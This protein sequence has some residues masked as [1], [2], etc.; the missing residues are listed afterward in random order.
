QLGGFDLAHEFGWVGLLLV[1]VGIWSC[2]LADRAFWV[3]IMTG[4]VS[5]WLMIAGYFNPQADVIFLTEEFYTPLYFLSAVLLAIG[6]FA[7]A[8][9]GAEIAKKPEKYGLLHLFLLML[10]YDAVMLIAGM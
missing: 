4:L 5:F 6:L 3:Y 2:W 9:R 1:F 10:S 7:V 8:A